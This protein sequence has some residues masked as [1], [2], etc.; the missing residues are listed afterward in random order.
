M[1]N[2]GSIMFRLLCG[3]CDSSLRLTTFRCHCRWLYRSIKS[4]IEIRKQW[5]NI[6]NLLSKFYSTLFLKNSTIV[7]VVKSQLTPQRALDLLVVCLTT[8]NPRD[9][10][11]KTG[12]TRIC[13]DLATVSGMDKPYPCTPHG[14]RKGLFSDIEIQLFPAVPTKIIL[15]K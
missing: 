5:N 13:A 1:Q 10:I 11:N 3:V 9:Y 4:N 14:R 7:E 15:D 6:F 8:R 2:T 12:T